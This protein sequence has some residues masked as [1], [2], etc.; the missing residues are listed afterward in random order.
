MRTVATLASCALLVWLAWD[1]RT[2]I[3]GAL[4]VL[5]A[6]YLAA[7]I[8]AGVLFTLVQA[9]IFAL[10]VP[11]RSGP[12]S[13]RKTMAAFLLSQPSKYL[14]GK[15]W[16]VFVQ[17]AILGPSARAVTI[18]I[19]NLQL[20]LI[21]ML[22]LLALGLLCLDHFSLRGLA[23]ALVIGPLAGTMVVVLP[24]AAVA[25]RLAPRMALRMDIRNEP[26]LAPGTVRDS[27]IGISVSM[28][29]NLL[30][31]T[32]LLLSIG[33]AVPRENLAGVLAVLYLGNIL[34]ALVVIVPAG[35]GIRELA[36]A[37]LGALLLP[38]IPASLIVTAA[39]VFR[40]WQVVVD[41]LSFALGWLIDRKTAP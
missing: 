35:I 9:R 33:D 6:D 40:L 29:A 24:V 20:F 36:A 10:L 41:V 16:P 13:A 22:H 14:P 37:A 34:G 7:S 26:A 4:G 1:A 25:R 8:V 21:S 12:G 32:A 28:V 11:G 2:E 31:S 23:A 38:G 17:A 3:A 19:A 5:R 15:I 39:V 27:A 18:T 30:A